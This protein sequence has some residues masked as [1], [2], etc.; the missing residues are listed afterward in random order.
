MDKLLVKPT[1]MTQLQNAIEKWRSGDFTTDDYASPKDNPPT[2]DVSVLASLV[3]DE[4]AIVREFLHDFGVSAK[5]ISVEL[6]TACNAGDLPHVS[7]QAHKLKS[8]ARSVGA[9]ALAALCEELE[10]AELDALRALTHRFTAEM[11]AVA[12]A[13][14]ELTADPVGVMAQG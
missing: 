14:I 1:T 5:A 6:L 13:V 10:V 2:L 12:S 3:G 9:I 7:R 4:P 11:D 8:S